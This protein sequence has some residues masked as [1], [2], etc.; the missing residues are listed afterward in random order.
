MDKIIGRV[1]SYNILNNIV[2][3]AILYF[4]I[5]WYWGVEVLG[6]NVV[7]STFLYY[8]LGMIISRIGS[9]IVEPIC[10][11]I[12]WIE[13][14]N[15][16]NFVVASKKDE[17]IEILSETNNLYRTMLTMFLVLLLGEAFIWLCENIRWI[18][19]VEKE[20]IAICLFLLFAA[21]YKKQTKYVNNR[22]DANRKGE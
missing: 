4:L 6:L 11:R 2:P 7:E 20:T 12:K 10:K 14:T 9:V 22:I 3:G 21:S 1:S 8:F 18:Y 15:Y 19:C 5:Q 17:K 13:F 16:R